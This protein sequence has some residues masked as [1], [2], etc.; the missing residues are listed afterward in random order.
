MSVNSLQTNLL[1]EEV[2][3]VAVLPAEVPELEKIEDLIERISLKEP[4]K[5]RLR[6]VEQ[7]QGIH[8]RDHLLIRGMDDEVFENIFDGGRPK[9][10]SYKQEMELMQRP[11]GL[12]NLSTTL[13]VKDQ[14]V[15]SYKS[16]GLLLNGQTATIQHICGTDSN[17]ASDDRDELIATNELTFRTLPELAHATRETDLLKKHTYNEVNGT[18]K[19]NDIE[20]LYIVVNPSMSSAVKSLNRTKIRVIQKLFFETYKIALPLMEYNTATGK[21]TPISLN[22]MDIRMDISQGVV[23]STG[24][25]QSL[26]P[27][28]RSYLS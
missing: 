10:G 8:E 15:G 23:S 2:P 9:L 7:I 11:K 14:G 3:A 21:L 17:S 1:L 26:Q 4:P 5:P 25:H 16:M 19:P 22:P 24:Y 20:G 27:Q 12:V 28:I 6:S 13:L 18:F